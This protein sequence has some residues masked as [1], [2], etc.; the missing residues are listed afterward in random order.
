MDY[1]NGLISCVLQRGDLGLVVE[2]GVTPQFFPE[3]RDQRVWTSMLDFFKNY[4]TTP[5]TD[6]ILASYPSYEIGQYP[7]STEYY[8]DALA[9][10]R[11]QAIIMNAFQDGISAINTEGEDPGGEAMKVMQD[12][13]LELGV[14]KQR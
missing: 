11:K 1:G 12:T 2:R 5:T 10:R 3:E 6:V 8:V 7:H 9:S 4:G 14:I 13:L